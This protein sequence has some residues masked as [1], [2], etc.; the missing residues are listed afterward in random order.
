MHGKCYKYPNINTMA[1]KL[2][3]SWWVLPC[4]LILLEGTEE[5][6]EIYTEE[7][8]YFP[9]LFLNKALPNFPQCTFNNKKSCEFF[10][11]KSP[12]FC[13]G[14]CDIPKFIR[15][16]VCSHYSAALIQLVVL[17]RLRL[18]FWHSHIFFHGVLCYF[19]GVS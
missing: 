5:C 11:C 12:D 14:Y 1:R 10:S 9:K 3:D 4:N 13:L 2:S 8:G 18:L 7:N 6:R 17:R 15:L 16:A 19:Y